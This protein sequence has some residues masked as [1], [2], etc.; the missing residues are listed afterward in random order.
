M[1]GSAYYQWT[2]LC[3]QVTEKSSDGESVA[4]GR[5]TREEINIKILDKVFKAYEEADGENF[6]LYLLLDDMLNNTVTDPY[7]KVAIGL[8]YPIGDR[9]ELLKEIAVEF[10]ISSYEEIQAREREEAERA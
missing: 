5:L 9:R 3:E 2:K 1:E 4:D 10:D 8:P 6:E 7:K